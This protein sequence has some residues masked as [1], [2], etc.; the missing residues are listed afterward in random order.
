MDAPKGP[1]RDPQ[2]GLRDCWSGARQTWHH[3]AKKHDNLH[4][5][6]RSKYVCIYIYTYIYILLYII[7]YKSYYLRP[8]RRENERMGSLNFGKVSGY[9][10]L[11]A[12][13]AGNNHGTV[14]TWFGHHD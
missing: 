12:K 14:P 5:L 3:A 2:S 11:K 4:M 1:K 10:I 9:H 8:M 13:I 7:I 6:I